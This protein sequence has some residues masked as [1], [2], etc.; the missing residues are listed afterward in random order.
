MPSAAPMGGGEITAN[1]SA[2]HFQPKRSVYRPPAEERAGG[3]VGCGFERK[4]RGV[5]V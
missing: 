4:A 2:S 1:E 5:A 3:P